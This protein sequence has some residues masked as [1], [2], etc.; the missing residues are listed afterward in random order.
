[1]GERW[2]RASITDT[3]KAHA[4]TG[5]RGARQEGLG[6]HEGLKRETPSHATVLGGQ[7]SSSFPC[8]SPP[9]TGHNSGAFFL[10]GGPVWDPFFDPHPLEEFM[11]LWVTFA[12]LP[13][14]CRKR[15]EYCFESTVS[16]KKTH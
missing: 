12:F 6:R 5:F 8:L 13:R 9:R 1:M 4:T 14:K 2:C 10:V 11:A 7:F 3:K 15:A 16:D